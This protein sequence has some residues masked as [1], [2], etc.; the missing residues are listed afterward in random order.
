MASSLNCLYKMKM[1]DP[2]CRLLVRIVMHTMGHCACVIDSCYT[3]IVIRPSGRITVTHSIALY[4]I[5]TNFINRYI[6]YRKIVCFRIPLYSGACNIKASVYISVHRHDCEALAN[7]YE[8]D[9]CWPFCYEVSL[10]TLR[11]SLLFLLP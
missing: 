2:R 11:S 1:K 9:C 10:E 7:Q 6:D 8:I 5:D 3:R 4:H